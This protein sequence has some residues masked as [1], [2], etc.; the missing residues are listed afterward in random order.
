VHAFTGTS[1]AA[2]PARKAVWQNRRPKR[3]VRTFPHQSGER[4]HPTRIRQWSYDVKRGAVESYDYSLH[5][6]LKGWLGTGNIF[7]LILKSSLN[8]FAG[9]LSSGRLTRLK[10]LSDS[11]IRHPSLPAGAKAA[12]F[13]DCA[14]QLNGETFCASP[15]QA[16][17]AS[18][19]N[20]DRETRQSIVKDQDRASASASLPM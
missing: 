3:R 1:R 15:C 2:G 9:S 12:L 10:V 11:L 6:E 4:R 18:P 5:S 14:F 20:S 8:V 17:Q 16:D 13:G 7:G 19:F